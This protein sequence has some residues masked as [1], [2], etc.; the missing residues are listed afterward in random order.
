MRIEHAAAA[1]HAA[2]E[3]ELIPVEEVIPLEGDEAL[4]PVEEVFSPHEEEIAVAELVE[5]EAPAQPPVVPKSKSGEFAKPV[6]NS[7]FS[8]PSDT[9][10]APAN[11]P[12]FGSAKPAE[13]A[14]EAS[15]ETPNR[16]PS[17]PKPKRPAVIITLVKPGDKSPF[18]E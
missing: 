10:T 5:P 6:V 11:R 1:E 18:A 7:A 13:P 17:P 3:E 9:P 4:V 14:Q 16:S 2:H 8:Q 15:N 12:A